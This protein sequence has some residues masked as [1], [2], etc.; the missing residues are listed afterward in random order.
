MHA[1]V[2]RELA[3]LIGN[4]RVKVYNILPMRADEYE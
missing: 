4:L 2:Y 1:L 3:R